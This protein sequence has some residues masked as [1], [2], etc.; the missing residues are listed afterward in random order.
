MHA[1]LACA[2]VYAHACIRVRVRVRVCTTQ[3]CVLFNDTIA[4]NIEYGRLG[5]SPEAIED[6]ARVRR[7]RRLMPGAPFYDLRPPRVLVP[8]SMN[9]VPRALGLCL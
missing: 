3:D 9:S 2:C 7:A 6:A 1:H 4:Y 8:P 5:S